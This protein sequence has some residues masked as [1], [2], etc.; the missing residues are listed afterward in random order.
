[1]NEVQQL[2]NKL[3]NFINELI[4]LFKKYFNNV[5]IVLKPGSECPECSC[6]LNIVHKADV[7]YGMRLIIYLLENFLE[8]DA[9]KISIVVSLDG[10][11]YLPCSIVEKL[12]SDQSVKIV[13][14]T[15]T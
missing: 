10:V 6:H 2:I 5:E 1:M 12:I 3:Q 7:D 11:V 15:C 13:K 8:K 9:N 4:Q 14:L